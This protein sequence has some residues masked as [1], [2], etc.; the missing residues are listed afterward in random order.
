VARFAAEHERPVIEV[1]DETLAVLRRCPWPGNVRQLRNALE[2]AVLLADGPVL[3][4]SHL[5][6]EVAA[7]PTP[8]RIHGGLCAEDDAPLTLDELVHGHIMRTLAATGGQLARAADLL[9]IHRNTLRR[10]LQEYGMPG[11]GSLD[12]VADLTDHARQAARADA[13]SQPR[14]GTRARHVENAREIDA[15]PE[16]G[17]RHPADGA[18]RPAV[19][20]PRSAR[21]GLS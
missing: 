14:K 13:D 3:L 15:W 6:A 17:E 8:G 2:R 18:L 9:G 12:D 20:L 5:P 7:L 4:P 16:H 19:V 21:L 10:K 11:D 1:A